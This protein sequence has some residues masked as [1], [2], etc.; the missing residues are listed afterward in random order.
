MLSETGHL[1]LTTVHARS[2]EQAL[3]KIIGSFSADEQNQIR[4]QLAENI[5]AIVVQK[6]LKRQDRPGLALAQEVL[7][8][9]TAVA[10]VIRENKLNQLKSIMYT[11]RPAGM[12]I[13]EENLLHLFTKGIISLEQALQSANNPEYIKRE[14]VN[15]G[16]V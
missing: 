9:T 7:L 4:V 10:N 5:S 1:V 11:N 3:N 14:L 8:N 2:A 6:L 15:R 12:Q 13:M 16:L